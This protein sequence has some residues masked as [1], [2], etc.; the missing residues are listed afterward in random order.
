MSP[1]LPPT[2]AFG[3]LAYTPPH[4]AA[5]AL[6]IHAHMWLNGGLCSPLAGQA[7]TTLRWSTGV[8]VVF[9]SGLGRFEINWVSVLSSQGTDRIRQGLQCTFGG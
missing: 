9:P 1:N 7:L 5:E 6:G 3:A 2:Q 4:P 8:G